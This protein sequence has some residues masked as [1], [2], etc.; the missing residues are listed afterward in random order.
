M[1]GST[2]T[3]QAHAEREVKSVT[4]GSLAFGSQPIL[5]TAIE[6]GYARG[7]NSS[8]FEPVN[9]TWYVIDV[10]WYW[11]SDDDSVRAATEDMRD[12]VDKALE[13]EASH[14]RYLFMYDADHERDAI[15]S[16]GGRTWEG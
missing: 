13:A 1:A 10:G 4:A 16:Y 8:I 14:V 15:A 5:S 9:Q 7:G 3:H 2:Y 11:P 6:A 12:E